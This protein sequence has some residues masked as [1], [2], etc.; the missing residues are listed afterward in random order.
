MRSTCRAALN[1]EIVAARLPDG[2][3]AAISPLVEGLAAIIDDVATTVAIDVTTMAHL[4]VHASSLRGVGALAEFATRTMGRLLDLRAAQL[5]LGA[6]P[7]G[8][9]AS[10]WRRP[11]RALRPIA[12]ERVRAAPST[13]L[14][15]TTVTVADAV[16]LGLAGPDEHF[17][18]ILWVPLRSGDTLIGTLVGR[19]DA[20]TA[21]SSLTRSAPTRR[22]SSPSTWR[23]S[24]TSRRR[25]DASSARP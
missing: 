21:R 25:S 14:S 16:D 8:P 6:N 9:P 2:C 15:D 18:R 3:E 23:P 10:F 19:S 11:D 4:C 7:T 1:I 12:A 17:R 13:G 24:S 22:R 5:D 20:R